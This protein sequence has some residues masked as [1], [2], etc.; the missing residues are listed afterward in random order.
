MIGGINVAGHITNGINRA[1]TGHMIGG[2]NRASV[3][4]IIG[5]IK[6]A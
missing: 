2:I 6:I 5:D 3:G 1:S 4:H